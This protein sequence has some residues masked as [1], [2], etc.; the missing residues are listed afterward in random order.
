MFK[1][2]K[3]FGNSNPFATVLA[4]LKSGNHI[5]KCLTCLSTLVAG[6]LFISIRVATQA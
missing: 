2:Y 4:Q 5:S 1:R 3:Y 6:F